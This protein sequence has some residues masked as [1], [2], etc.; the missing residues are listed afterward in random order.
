MPE[1]LRFALYQTHKLIVR[2]PGI[3]YTLQMRGWIFLPEVG[4]GIP[5]APPAF[6][7]DGMS[8]GLYL[9][10]FLLLVAG[11]AYGLTLMSVPGQW[12]A[13]AVVTLLGLGI[14][15]GVSRTRMR[16]PS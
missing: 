11:V 16:D 12:I 3:I 5:L 13:V 9:I 2:I 7:G 6:G 14:I 4:Y 8:F 10:G 15:S 1:K